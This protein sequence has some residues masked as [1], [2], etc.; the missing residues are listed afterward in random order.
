MSKPTN[1]QC[2]VFWAQMVLEAETDRDSKDPDSTVFY[3]TILMIDAQLR[4]YRNKLQDLAAQS[5]EALR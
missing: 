5:K 1:P 3:Q 2:E 4:Y